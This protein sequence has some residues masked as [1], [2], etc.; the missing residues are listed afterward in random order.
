MGGE[1]EDEIEEKEEDVFYL[2]RLSQNDFTKGGF[3][4]CERLCAD[5]HT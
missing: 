2:I 3:G 4:G 1:Q 5:E